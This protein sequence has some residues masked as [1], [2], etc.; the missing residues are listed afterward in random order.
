MAAEHGCN[1]CGAHHREDG[2]VGRRRTVD[3][4]EPGIGPGGGSQCGTQEWQVVGVGLHAKGDECDA[5][6]ALHTAV[7]ARRP[8][9]RVSQRFAT[10]PEGVVVAHD[11]EERPLRQERAQRAKQIAVKQ[12][13][14]GG[15]VDVVAERRG[16]RGGLRCRHARHCPL[17]LATRAVVAK[18]DEAHRC[19]GSGGW[20]G[21]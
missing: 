19:P 11:P 21:N 16:E 3:D 1:S 8:A 17:I 14:R 9:E 10:F 20:C 5:T 2:V 15:Q 13:G 18:G 6:V 7:A 4:D 12:H